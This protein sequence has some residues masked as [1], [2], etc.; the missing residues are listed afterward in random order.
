MEEL[1]ELKQKIIDRD[2]EEAMAIVEDLEE[3]GRKGL[4]A[5]IKSYCKILLLH[6]I[7]QEAEKRT[8]RSWDVSIKNSVNEILDLNQMRKASGHY[9]S[10]EELHQ[11]LDKSFESALDKASLE[12]FGGAFEIEEFKKMFDRDRVMFIATSKLNLQE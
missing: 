10:D 11:I 6:I 4:E 9:F 2:W 5:A 1:A 3:M 7:K 12:A 8:T